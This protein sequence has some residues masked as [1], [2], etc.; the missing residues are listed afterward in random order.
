VTFGEIIDGM[1]AAAVRNLHTGEA[2]RL[3]HDLIY[4]L[5]AEGVE[6]HALGPFPWSG[7][8][9]GHEG[10]RRWF[11]ILNQ[12]MA[13]AQFELREL[14]EDGDTVVEIVQASGTAVAT[15]KP[16]ASEIAR[17][18]TFGADGKATRVR[19]YYDT[20]AYAEALRP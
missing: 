1:H 10:V 7:S 19:S 5:L 12:A 15:G 3:R 20:Y 18:W 11:E 8:H 13:Y 9:Y 16:F 14:Y 6:W 2:G 17:V 4:D